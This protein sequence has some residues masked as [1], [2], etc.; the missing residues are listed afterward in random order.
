MEHTL[1]QNTTTHA[2]QL[3]CKE[4]KTTHTQVHYNDIGTC[5]RRSLLL[6][7]CCGQ[8]NIEEEEEEEEEE[9]G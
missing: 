9:L 1:K 7:V 8:M 3:S 2:R 5:S 4:L 6:H